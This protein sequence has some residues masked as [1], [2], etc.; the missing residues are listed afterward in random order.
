MKGLKEALTFDDVL[1]VPKRSPI[2]SRKD[3]D[4]STFLTPKIKMNI[5]LVS[6]N[7]DTVTESQMAI[8]MARKGGIGIIHRFMTPERQ[9]KEVERVKRSES[10]VIEEPYTCS[11]T[12]TIKE[13]RT[14]MYKKDVNGILVVDKKNKLLG[15]VTNRDIIFEDSPKK[16]ISKVM[17]K[18]DDLITSS[19]DITMKEAKEIFRKEKIEKIPLVDK[20]GFLKGLITSKDLE[21]ITE[22]PNATKDKKGR[23]R[24]GAAIGVKIDVIERTEALLK[25]GCDFIVVDIAHGHSDLCIDTI[26]AVKENFNGTEVIAGN[27][28]TAEATEELIKAGADGI[29]VG[30]GPGSTCITRIVTG[31]GVPQLTA[32]SDC[33]GIAKEYNIPVMAD[34]GLRTSGDITKALAAGASSVMSGFFFAG[35]KETPGK[36]IIKN[37]RKYKIYRGSASLGSNLTTKQKRDAKKWREID[38]FDITPEGVEACVPY[39]GNVSEVISKLIGGL[40]SGMS[41]CGAKTI[42]E[43]QK[44]AE[45]IKMSGSGLAESYSHDLEVL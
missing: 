16:R 27:V 34:G 13:V 2:K 17:T 15:I 14:L 36:E 24:V 31:S 38:I 28:A 29:K 39:R 18:Y 9:A 8:A 21:K 22:F 7:M 33:A 44:N 37:G 20:K 45:F 5:P 32:I 3:V 12:N 6:T 42:G 26:K 19:P 25:V 10:I 43:M 30:I 11:S 23:L 41:Y 40:R 1:L 4:T 35:T